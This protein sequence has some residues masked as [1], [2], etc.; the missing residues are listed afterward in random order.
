MIDEINDIYPTYSNYSYSINTSLKYATTYY[1]MVVAY[2]DWEESPSDIWDFTTVQPPS[3]DPPTNIY[4][5][6]S[7]ID[8]PLNDLELQWQVTPAVEYPI[9]FKIYFGDTNPPP[10]IDDI[11]PIYNYN[12]SYSIDTPLK[13]ATTY[14]W[15]VVAYNDWEES[16][17]DIWDFTTQN[18]L[19][20]NIELISF[21]TTISNQNYINLN[22][23]SQ[24]ENNLIG[25]YVLKNREKKLETAEVISPLISATNN[26]ST[27]AYLFT[28]TELKESGIYYYWLQYNSVDGTFGFYG[29]LEVYYNVNDTPSSHNFINTGLG[30]IYPNPFNQIVY[31]PYTLET[32]S[33]VKIEI[34]NSK[35]ERI[36]YMDLANQDKG[37]HRIMWDGKD[38]KSLNCSNGI[39]IL[40]MTT[41][42]QV[43]IKKMLM[44]K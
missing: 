13:Y 11:Y 34:Y 7:Q 32:K 6:T 44:L 28:D 35:G 31:I 8:I 33:E 42:N 43:Y 39:Y 23:V 14:Y 36:K 17:S 15:M 26:S 22:W 41:N 20:L 38:D 16:P 25:Y 9:G 2:N 12:Y 30:D 4:P 19:S 37:Y 24:S 29:P 10:L 21:F 3:L 27:I 1:W 5:Y 40:R 18:E